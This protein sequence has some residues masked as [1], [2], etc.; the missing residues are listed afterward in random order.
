M[1]ATFW[2]GTC[3][4]V[5]IKLNMYILCNSCSIVVGFRMDFLWKPGK[6]QEMAWNLIVAHVYEPCIYG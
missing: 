1:T 3:G 5:I 2:Q 4:Y 6:S